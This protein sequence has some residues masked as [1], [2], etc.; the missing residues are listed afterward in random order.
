MSVSVVAV[1]IVSKDNKPL[2][3]RTK[4]DF[5]SVDGHESVG[6]RVPQD[7]E[8]LKLVFL[9][10]SSLDFVDEK[11]VCLFVSCYTH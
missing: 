6:H 9:M 10:N 8:R 11:Q 4:Y 7:E 2:A 5:V 3:I 1:A